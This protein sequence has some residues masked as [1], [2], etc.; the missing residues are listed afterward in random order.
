MVIL[1]GSNGRA[2]LTAA[3]ETGAPAAFPAASMHPLRA[4]AATYAAPV[5]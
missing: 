2:S 1:V 4:I 3:R 5:P